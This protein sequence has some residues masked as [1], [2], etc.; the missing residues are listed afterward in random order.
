MGKSGIATILLLVMTIVI[1]M[2]AISGTSGGIAAWWARITGEQETEVVQTD[3]VTT[4]RH[5]NTNDGMRQI[6]QA[7]R[8]MQ[9]MDSLVNSI[10]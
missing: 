7:R 8:D 5:L 3:D 1:V 9:A 10:R 6:D 4:P 2:L